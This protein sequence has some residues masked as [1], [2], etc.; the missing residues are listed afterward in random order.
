V[1]Y[2]L[3]KAISERSHWVIVSSAPFLGI[4]MDRRQFPRLQVSL[5]IEYHANIHDS[6]ASYS[7]KAVLKNISIGGVY[8]VSEGTPILEPGD[9]ADFIFKLMHNH[10]NSIITKEIRGKGRVTRV[11][12]QDEESFNFG[13]AVEFLS[14]PLFI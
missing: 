3:L 5:P 4:L 8:F 12:N 10:S 7:N 1:Y 6:A 2:L 13:I 11:E 9:I 14:G